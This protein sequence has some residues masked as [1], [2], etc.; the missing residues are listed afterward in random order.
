MNK[1]EALK[2]YFGYDSFRGGQEEV[3]DAILSRRDTLAIMPTGAGKSVCYQIPALISNGITIVI[4]PL[5]SLM[6]DQVT[7]LLQAGVRAAYINTSLTPQ[8]ISQVLRNASKGI[9]KIIYVAPERLLTPGFLCFAKA[10]N[11]AMV[12]VDEAHCV[13]QWGQDFRQS[14]LDIPNFV[15]QLPCRPIVS[16][17][18]ATATAEVKK[19]IVKMLRLRDPF[20]IT[21]GFDRKNLYFAV[22]APTDKYLSLLEILRRHEN[23]SVIVYCSTRKTVEE[24]AEKLNTNGFSVT[25]Y[26]AGLS[27]TE[28]GQNQEDFI[29]DRKKI[30]AATNAFGMGID[31]SDVSCVIHYNMPKDIESYYQEAGRAGRDGSPAECILLYSGQDVRTQMYFIEHPNDEA[32]LDPKTA[33]ILRDRDFNR[34]RAMVSYCRTTECLRSH[35]LRYFGESAPGFCG[36]C[37]NCA[38][39]YEIMDITVDAQKILSCIYRMGQKYGTRMVIDVL[40]GS[41]AKRI[42]DLQFDKLSTHGIMKDTPDST[43]EKEI[44]FL[45]YSGYI[46]QTED[47]YPVLKL[48]AAANG[49][50]FG[51]ITVSMRLPKKKIIKMAAAENT[52]KHIDPDLFESLK[53]LREAVAAVQSVPAFIVLPDSTL[54]SMCEILPRNMEEMGLVSGMGEAKLQR[55]GQKFLK[56]IEEYR[57]EHPEADAKRILPTEKQP[58]S[59]KKSENI[60][61]PLREIADKSGN[62]AEYSEDIAL[63]QLCEHI[64]EQAKIN[65]KANQLFKPAREWLAENGYL[66]QPDEGGAWEVTEKG[67]SVGIKRVQRTAKSGN[68]YFTIL[69]TPSAQKFVIDNLSNI[70]DFYEKSIV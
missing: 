49:V 9:Y 48:T 57:S 66:S 23:E 40:R 67:S 2:S 69:Y 5:I 26:H 68:T 34:L 43:I 70:E 1:Y 35:I 24:V 60:T 20:T 63:T 33:K 65:L 53:V 56:K 6:K 38:G 58:R 22:E 50:L 8:Q 16:A 61:L 13:S 19:D 32:D 46:H 3:I 64:I 31:K 17:F 55:Y 30:I 36:N 47:E 21:T 62:I 4:S 28:R 27:E 37:S 10:A 29:F 39:E 52:E 25:R 54:R 45:T 11:I 14:Y 44:I 41:S 42:R 18:T 7:A 51:Q 59:K 15:A 12:T